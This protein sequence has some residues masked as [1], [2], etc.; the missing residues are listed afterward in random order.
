MY[1]QK[2]FD[3]TITPWYQDKPGAVS[4]SFDDASFTQYQFAFPVFKKYKLN[5]TFSLVGEWTK[6]Q[7]TYSAEPDM[8]LIKKMGWQQIRELLQAGNEIAAHGYR[9]IRYGKYLPVDTLTR[10]MLQVK[11]L[12]EQHTGQPVYTMH[13]PY[14]FTSDSIKKATE[15]S[16]FL[17]ARTGAH[18][19]VNTYDNFQPHLLSSRAIL[20]DTIPNM[21][22][23]QKWMDDSKGA[24][25]ILM[26]HHLFPKGSKEMHIMQ[27]HNVL[28]TYSLYP[29]TFDKQMKIVAESP[30]WVAP[31]YQVGM[32][33][34][35]RLHTKIKT[36]K[37]FGTYRIKT[38]T[39]LDKRIYK[40]KLTLKV[41]IPWKKVLVKIGKN[42]QTYEVNG[43]YLLID[44]VPG[45]TII[46][47][48]K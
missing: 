33:M 10:Q 16:G 18:H 37:C 40:Q 19:L 5:A 14:S 41:K 42:K 7:A 27:A 44:F 26:Y 35:E 34:Q 17:F 23:F 29:E 47:K 22:T 36:H 45:D 31:E 48:K 1:S 39:G 12:I 13:Y 28:H 24:W 15:K 32:Y 46:I 2:K 25:T 4:I 9:H 38:S 20:N 6:D 11:K 21:K 3:A 43:T 30:Y 8:F